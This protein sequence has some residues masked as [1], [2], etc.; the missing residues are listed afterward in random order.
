MNEPNEKKRDELIWEFITSLQCLIRNTAR[1]L[2]RNRGRC[3]EAD[4]I[5]GHMNLLLFRRFKRECDNGTYYKRIKLKGYL[6]ACISGE[7][8]RLRQINGQDLSL[9]ELLEKEH[10]NN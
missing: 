6:R 5:A 4:D 3:L 2:T 9:D 8:V 1:K 10:K 7:T